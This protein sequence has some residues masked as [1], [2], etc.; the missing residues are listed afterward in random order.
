MD[1][2]DNQEQSNAGVAG[3]GSVVTAL[4]VPRS[5]Q[6]IK[7]PPSERGATSSFRKWL[8]QTEWSRH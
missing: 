5:A 1:D 6:A 2:I 7:T 3:H 8:Q 4:S